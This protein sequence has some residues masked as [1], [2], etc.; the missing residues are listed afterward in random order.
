MS[1]RSSCTLYHSVLC[2]FVAIW[3]LPGCVSVKTEHKIEPIHITMDVNLRLEK[4]LD[5]AFAG[6]DAKTKQLAKDQIEEGEV[7]E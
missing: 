6:L 1:L 3:A 7:S 4:E 2:L 5:D